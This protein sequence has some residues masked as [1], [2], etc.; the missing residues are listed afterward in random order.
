MLLSDVSLSCLVCQRP[1]EYIGREGGQRRVPSERGAKFMV[2]KAN[3]R[4]A[5]WLADGCNRPLVSS[6]QR[7]ILGNPKSIMLGPWS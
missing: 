7:T 2:N 1:I 5:G 6:C 4:L 3:V